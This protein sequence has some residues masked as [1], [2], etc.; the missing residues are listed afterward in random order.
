MIQTSAKAPIEIYSPTARRLHW[1]TVVLLLI[2]IPVGLYMVYRGNALNIW[3]TLTNVLYSGHKL[4][5]VTILVVVIWRLAYRFS[6]GAPADEPT[7]EPWH[8]IVSRLNH[9]GIYLLLLATPIA[10]YI[11]ISLFP[12][13]D[14][15]G[16]P[17]PGVV[18]PDKEAA[19]TA[20]AIHGLLVLLLVLMIALH[21]GAA[22]YHYV[23]RKDN[24]LGRMIPRMLRQPGV[25]AQDGSPSRRIV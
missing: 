10:G 1:T 18:A 20:F 9:W 17:L 6:R 21:V 19:K 3:D 11:G 25:P 7:I 23:I 8:R 4:I 5:G 24:V 12:A 22:L 16:I 14:I 2:Q 15:F 13:L